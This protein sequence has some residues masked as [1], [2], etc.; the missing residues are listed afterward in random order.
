VG[1]NLELIGRELD[2]ARRRYLAYVGQGAD[3]RADDHLAAHAI[4]A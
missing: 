3:P 1:E 2:T 4:A